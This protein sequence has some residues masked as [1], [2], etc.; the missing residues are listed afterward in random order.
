MG[1]LFDVLGDLARDRAPQ[2]SASAWVGRYPTWY[3]TRHEAG[4]LTIHSPPSMTVG[5]M[6]PGEPR[7]LLVG[8]RAP[9]DVVARREDDGH[10]GR[11]YTA[12][13][14]R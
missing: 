3:V 12:A 5:T 9:L 10:E 13:D 4:W 7:M 2:P 11:E 8:A 6:S 14:I 1:S